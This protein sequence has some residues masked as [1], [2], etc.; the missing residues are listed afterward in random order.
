MPSLATDPAILIAEDDPNDLFLFKQTL[1]DLG[2]RNP[3][4]S[5]GNGRE[6]IE[7][8]KRFCLPD[9]THLVAPALLFLDM[10]LPQIDG[11]AVIAWVKHQSALRG[12]RVVVLSGSSEP[13]D[14]RAASSLGADRVLVKPPQ[15]AVIAEEVAS[16]N[17]LAPQR[18][19]P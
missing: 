15:P 3:V 16:L 9:A 5:F 12:L 14:M 2:L 11:R 4:R 10:H 6:V 18:T 7:H 1:S 13:E 8:L 17:R 19:A